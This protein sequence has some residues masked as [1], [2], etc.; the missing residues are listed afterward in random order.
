MSLSLPGLTLVLSVAVCKC[1]PRR[2][3]GQALRGHQLAN[4]KSL[5][6]LWT[7]EGVKILTTCY[8]WTRNTQW[9][10]ESMAGYGDCIRRAER[11]GI[12]WCVLSRRFN[13]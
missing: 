2:G 7:R 4:T 3:L 13:V 9:A 10:G 11:K 6:T 1:R 8:F 5:V 12:G